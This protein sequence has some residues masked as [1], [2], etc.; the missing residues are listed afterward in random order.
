MDGDWVVTVILIVIVWI[1]ACLNNWQTSKEFLYGILWG[2][3]QTIFL[4]LIGGL[5]CWL[6]YLWGYW[7]FYVVTILLIGVLVYLIKR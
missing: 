4:V 5:I 2:T 1:M 7:V 6:A 3:I